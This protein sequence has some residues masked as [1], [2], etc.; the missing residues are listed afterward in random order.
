MLFYDAVSS[1]R[2][3]QIRRFKEQIVGLQHLGD[4]TNK[5]GFDVK[6]ERDVVMLDYFQQTRAGDFF[7]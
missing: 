6:K 1:F 2:I 7:R 3:V 4:V 5:A